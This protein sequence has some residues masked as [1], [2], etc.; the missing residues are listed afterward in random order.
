KFDLSSHESLMKGG[1]RG[2]PLVAGKAEES[3]IYKLAG[4][5]HKPFM[6]P[7]GEEPLTPE[8]LAVVKLW[9][10][11]GAKPPA[12]GRVKPKVGVSGPPASV[13]PVHG[14]AVSPDHSA[15]AAARGNEIH[16]YDAGSGAYLRSLVDPAL[17]TPDKK[18]LRAAHLSLVESLVYSP[19]GKFLVC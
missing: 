8:E 15:V 1:K 14:V 19:D 11:Q 6:P 9:I 16:V 13:H 10:D 12:G 3:L 18:P 2:V 4:K 17:T 5:T 7:R